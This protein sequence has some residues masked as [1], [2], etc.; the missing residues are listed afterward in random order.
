MLVVLSAFLAALVVVNFV[1]RNTKKKKG[2]SLPPGPRPLPLLGNVIGVKA[3]EPWITYT[4]WNDTYGDIIY[5]RFLG[6]E[7]V[8]LGSEETAKTLLERRSSNYSDR[9]FF[10]VVKP[11]GLAFSSAFMHYGDRWRLHRRLLHQALRPDAAIK[12]HP[13][14]LRK[15]RQLLVDLLNAPEDF[16]AHLATHSSAIIMDIVYGYET[17]PRNDPIVTV[18]ERAMKSLVR[19]MTP[20]KSAVVSTFWFLLSLPPWFPGATLKREAMLSRAYNNDLIEIPYQYVRSSMAAGTA[21]SSMVAD[22]IHRFTS[23]DETGTFEKAIKESSATAFGAASETTSSTL[24]VFVLTMIHHPQVQERAQSE[25]D[26]VVGSRRL[27][28]FADRPSMPYMEAILRETLR[29]HPV[30]PLG[31]PHATGKTDVFEGYYIPKGAT[32]LANTWAMSRNEA[33]YPNPS[34]FRP[35]RFFSPNGEL[36]D[37]KV[38]FAFGFGRRIC[39]GRHVAD[40]S[41]WS[42]MVSMLAIFKF[43]KPL[44]DTGREIDIQVQWTSGVTSHPVPF[45]CRIVPRAPAMNPEELGRLIANNSDE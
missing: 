6:Q 9:P 13:L 27:P 2:A 4:E 17:S 30:V 42:A 37:D 25:I 15:A 3:D 12:V 31:V 33:K 28:N 41:L 7:I 32:I 24:L 19:A 11:Y 40:A 10:A 35:E 39:V 26:S 36:N 14:Q 5:T 22:C 44:D 8:V 29:W 21:G 34:E 38:S 43:T 45:P 16:V 18:A 20:Q 23:N 1:Y